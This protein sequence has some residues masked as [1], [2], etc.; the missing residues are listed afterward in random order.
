MKDLI[1]L[2]KSAVAE[3]TPELTQSLR[4]SAFEQG[5]NAKCGRSLS[6]T[7]DGEYFSVE[8]S[9]EAEDLEYGVM[10]PP[11]PAVRLWSNDESSAS[12]SVVRSIE[13]RL[14]GVL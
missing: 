6:V 1:Q 4:Q 7:C 9:D 3:A 8:M 10:S 14:E 13:R 2:V 12:E 5:W 11:S